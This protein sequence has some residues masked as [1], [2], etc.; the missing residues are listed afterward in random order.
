MQDP[1]RFSG[2]CGRDVVIKFDRRGK[3]GNIGV[4]NI[5]V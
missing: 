3:N 5:D 1:I 2:G 4:D